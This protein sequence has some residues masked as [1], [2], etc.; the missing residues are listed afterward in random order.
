[1]SLQQRLSTLH[2]QI[3]VLLSEVD[4]I[5]KE[6]KE[7]QYYLDP[8]MTFE[9]FIQD[10]ITTDYLPTISLQLDNK[11]IFF[12]KNHEEPPKLLNMNQQPIQPEDYQPLFQAIVQEY[13]LRTLRH[14]ILYQLD[15]IVK[16]LEEQNKKQND[17]ENLYLKH[18]LFKK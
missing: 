17:E 16:D 6:M 7:S 2:K 15:D 4:S 10:Q 13:G 11:S 8:L 3:E 14:E 18:D 9:Y 12:H 1:M 5:E